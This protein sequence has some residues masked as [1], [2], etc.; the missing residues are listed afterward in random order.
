M[1]Q[2][3]QQLFNQTL[4]Y[5]TKHPLS[6]KCVKKVKA[7]VLSGVGKRVKKKGI[8]RTKPIQNERR[9]KKKRNENSHSSRNQDL[10][11]IK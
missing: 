3:E 6:I 10:L 8:F 2:N 7:K 1:T 11:S 9:L 5:F 4:F